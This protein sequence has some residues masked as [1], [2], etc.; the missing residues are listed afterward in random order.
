MLGVFGDASP[1]YWGRLVIERH[2]GGAELSEAEYLRRVDAARV[3]ALSF[4]LDPADAPSPIQV[5]SIGSLAEL[6]DAAAAVERDEPVDGAVMTLLRQGT[7]V[8]GARPK[9]TVAD[10]DAYWIA[11]SSSRNDRVDVPAVES[12]AR[13]NTQLTSGGRAN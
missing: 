8:G 5:P 7:S 4:A 6:V 2:A 1:D 3:G 10:G 13:S 11:K 9:A 12:V